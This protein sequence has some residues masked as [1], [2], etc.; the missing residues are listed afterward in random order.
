V[1]VLDFGGVFFLGVGVK[2]C[3]KKVYSIQVVRCGIEEKMTSFEK[4]GCGPRRQTVNPPSPAA[5]RRHT[6]ARTERSA[7][8]R[9][10]KQGEAR[11]KI[12]RY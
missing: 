5:L 11:V 7:A 12:Q 10:G 9:G 4:R 6:V 8:L 2:S 1:L 3:A